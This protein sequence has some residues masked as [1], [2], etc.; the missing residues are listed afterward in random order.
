MKNDKEQS[1]NIGQQLLIDLYQCDY[2]TLN[3]E[4]KLTSILK[5]AVE[6]CGYQMLKT[7]SH[8]YEPQG[9]SVIVIIAESH[10]SIHTWPEYNWAAIDIFTCGSILK[11]NHIIDFFSTSL[12]AGNY[13]S[14]NILRGN[15]EFARQNMEKKVEQI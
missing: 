4:K 7:I 3:N 13:T 12:K 9:I 14:S 6:I 15:M 11:R 2:E 1:T 8:K 10:F 5:E